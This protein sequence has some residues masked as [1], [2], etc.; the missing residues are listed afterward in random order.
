MDTGDYNLTMRKIGHFEFFFKST[1]ISASDCPTAP[2][3][4]WP[5]VIFRAIGTLMISITSILSTTCSVLFGL[6]C[7]E[8]I[9]I[10][11]DLHEIFLYKAVHNRPTQ[12][13]MLKG[14]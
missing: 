1:V 2:F 10:I 6:R 5:L 11:L 3:R 14:A 8:Q 12:R 7:K 13:L 4:G 9:A